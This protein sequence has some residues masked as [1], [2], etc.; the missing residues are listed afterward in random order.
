MARN[1]SICK[2]SFNPRTHVGC[3]GCKDE[4]FKAQTLFQSTHPR[5]VR[6]FV[7]FFRTIRASFNPRTHVGCDQYGM[8]DYHLL[9]VS[10]HAPTWG[11]TDAAHVTALE[12]LFQSTHP[13]GVRLLT[14]QGEVLQR[15]FNPRTHVGCDLCPSAGRRPRSSFN[16]RTHVGCDFSM[17]WFIPTSKF[18]STHPR[19]VRL[20]FVITKLLQLLFQS[21]HPRG[22]RRFVRTLHIGLWNV[23]IH[24][25]T[26]GAT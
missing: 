21:T 23:S 2:P 24:A 14:Y 18:Q 16:P 26:W 8:A 12:F 6:L 10:I 17:T 11:A 19:G 13:R 3:D 15:C 7:S 4:T 5:G 25:P 1:T 22:V 20:R 9:R